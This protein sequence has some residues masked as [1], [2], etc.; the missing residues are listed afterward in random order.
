MY[1]RVRTVVLLFLAFVACICGLFRVGYCLPYSFAIFVT[2]QLKR[3]KFKASFS[4]V[5]SHLQLEQQSLTKLH[6]FILNPVCFAS[7]ALDQ[8]TKSK[9]KNLSEQL[10]SFSFF[11][12]RNLDFYN[13]SYRN[14]CTMSIFVCL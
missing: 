4:P 1:I 5:I 7:Y 8:T 13:L 2:F 10:K 12:M 3:K 9:Q 6:F 14:L 11:T